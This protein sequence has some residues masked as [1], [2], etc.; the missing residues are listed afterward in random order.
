MPLRH[1]AHGPHL[2]DSLSTVV[3]GRMPVTRHRVWTTAAAAFGAIVWVQCG[4]RPSRPVDTNTSTNRGSWIGSPCGA[5]HPCDA[6]HATCLSGP[7]T[8]PP[9][10]VCTGYCDDNHPCP[11]HGACVQV[12][13]SQAPGM[14]LAPCASNSDCRKGWSCEPHRVSGTARDDAWSNVCW[15]GENAGSSLG[16]SCT[17][18]AECI[19]DLCLR[20]SE[21][22][23]VCSVPCKD[24]A[25]CLPGFVCKTDIATT[26]T[27][28]ECAYCVRARRPRQQLRLPFD[29]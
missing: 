2:N 21:V 11:D 7:S 15:A 17:Q 26:C 22:R 4:G 29:S 27:K 6:S 24:G 18:D 28:E 20:L 13:W 25:T 5:A 3:V 19:S 9:G 8:N 23:A 12:R 14:C 10:G 1:L 16:E